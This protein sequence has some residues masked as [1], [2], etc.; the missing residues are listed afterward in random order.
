MLSSIVQNESKNDI[1]YQPLLNFYEL[2]SGLITKQDRVGPKGGPVERYIASVEIV[3]HQGDVIS[4]EALADEMETY[5]K[6]NGGIFQ[7]I[8]SNFPA[9]QVLEWGFCK[10]AGDVALWIDVEFYQFYDSQKEFYK[11]TKLP[12]GHKEKI[13]GVSLG[14]KAL[15]R[16]RV[17]NS[18][19]CFTHIK[20]L[21]AWEISGVGEPANPLA[22]KILP[23][24]TLEGIGHK[25][26][27]YG[28]SF[29]ISEGTREKVSM[30]AVTKRLRGPDGRFISKDDDCIDCSEDKPIVK[31]KD[32]SACDGMEKH[33]C[34][35][36]GS[37]HGEYSP[38]VDQKDLSKDE[39]EDEET[40][41]TLYED[42]QGT[43][44]K[45]DSFAAIAKP[46][47]KEEKGYYKEAKPDFADLDGDGNKTESMKD[48]ADDKEEKKMYVKEDDCPT[49]KGE[50]HCEDKGMYAKELSKADTFTNYPKSAS[51]NA[52]KVLEWKEKYGDEVK[53]M[54]SVGW[55]RARQLAKR[56]ALSKDTVKRMAQ[57]NRH[58][59]NAKIDPKYKDT[60]WKDNGY[61][62]WLGW[63]GTSG[64]NWAIRTS[65]S[66]KKGMEENEMS[67]EQKMAK[68]SEYPIE[69]KDKESE[70][71]MTQIEELN[72]KIDTMMSALNIEKMAELI[73]EKISKNNEELMASLGKGTTVPKEIVKDGKTYVLKADDDEEEEKGMGMEKEEEE[74]D[75]E[76]K[77]AFTAKI[78][79][80]ETLLKSRFVDTV[81][82][83]PAAQDD[84]IEKGA[85]T[86]KSDLLKSVESA[87]HLDKI[88]HRESYYNPKYS[89]D[90]LEFQARIKKAHLQTGFDPSVLGMSLPSNEL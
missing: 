50:C 65:E 64:V 56:E 3:D 36:C 19:G 2:P 88:E 72:Q 86:F 16:E 27:F 46:S 81:A 20:K 40:E 51:N 59:Q 24:N 53:G 7:G 63:G 14:G 30:N 6:G 82:T 18:N 23:D 42:A 38:E 44:V 78:S 45:D 58:R 85:T 83:N 67:D 47:D 89:S 66:F 43:V 21:E 49:C 26:E 74:E 76:M 61:V 39:D 79:E 41:K 75:D 9:G 13:S 1:F 12:W 8:H 25:V 54:T 15:E 35:H 73:D 48:A 71:D 60:P 55:N 31:D 77:K 22:R 4:V 32:C 62:A 69:E 10:V 70:E 52:K 29:N 34:K 90:D 28:K 33:M 80:L 17:C 11:R 87:P 57:F 37:K 5:I 68:P 84:N